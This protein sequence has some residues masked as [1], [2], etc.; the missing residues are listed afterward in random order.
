LEYFCLS[1]L[2]QC[3][4]WLLLYEDRWLF[5]GC[6]ALRNRKYSIQRP[7]AFVRKKE[8]ASDTN[9]LFLTHDTGLSM[10]SRSSTTSA[11]VPLDL[12]D[13]SSWAPTMV[14]LASRTVNFNSTT[15][16]MPLG[17]LPEFSPSCQTYATVSVCC[18]S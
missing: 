12:L 8:T 2:C 7:I 4:E 18:F 9:V 15:F 6:R 1:I 11:R 5:D 16:S 14:S 10:V 17:K 13:I 3:N